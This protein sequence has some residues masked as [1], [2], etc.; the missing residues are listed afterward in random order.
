M[1]D[2]QIGFLRRILF[3][4]T[5]LFCL[6]YAGLALLWQR[7]DPFAWYVP[8]IMGLA[9]GLILMVQRFTSAK[10]TKLAFD[11]RYDMSATRAAG[12][13]FWIM[14]FSLP[15]FAILQLR[16]LVSVETAYAATGTLG[17]ASYLLMNVW[18]DWK[19]AQ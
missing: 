12:Y 18:F 9:A 15:F 2:D 5:G 16:E 19:E 4:M 8:G 14:L 13:A 10:A 6:A 11:E 1:T 3:G 17:A 7:P